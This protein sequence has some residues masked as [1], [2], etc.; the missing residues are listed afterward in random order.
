MLGGLA[1]G[2]LLGSMFSGG[3]GGL[4]GILLAALLGIA[5]V[6]ALRM[7]LR[8]RAA[9]TPPMQFAGLGNETVAAPPPLY[10]T[11]SIL[12]FAMLLSSEPARC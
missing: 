10:G 4:G 11:S 9:A 7:V 3:L 12:I 6:V 1:I 2:G 5:I 8:P